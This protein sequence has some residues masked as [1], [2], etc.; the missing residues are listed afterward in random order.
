MAIDIFEPLKDLQGNKQKSASWYRNAVS[1]I[2]DRSS[3][4]ELF[5][6]GKMLGRPSGGRMSMFF[7][8]PKTKNRLPYYDTF[9]L[10]LP[11][12]TAKGGFIGLNFHYLPYGAR[13][14][15]LQTLQTYAS[16]KKFDQS[17]KIQASYDSIKGN[18][19][20]KASIKRYLY[21]QVR[22]NFLRIDVNEMALAAYLPVAQFQGA[23]LGTVFAR[24]RKTF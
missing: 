15:F 24:S 5:A 1:L 7:Y 14:A 8:D 16:N 2:A 11:L 20:T 22:S 4:S 17:T 18:K 19:Y 9:P 12:E 23:S 6:S 21:S 10:V 3:P 13:F